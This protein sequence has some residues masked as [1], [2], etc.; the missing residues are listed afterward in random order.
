ML[1]GPDF[2]RS[3]GGKF[4]NMNQIPPPPPKK[5]RAAPQVEQLNPQN[6]R[7]VF[8]RLKFKFFVYVLAPS[9]GEVNSD[10]QRTEQAKANLDPRMGPRV[11]PRVRPREHP[12]QDPRGLISL[13]SGFS[14]T[15]TKAPAKRP[16]RASTEVSTKVSSQVVEVHLSC[17]HLF[18]SSAK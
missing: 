12:R 7:L 1:G 4:E 17:F 2:S 6:K 14:R 13:F 5:K 11:D 18:C 9:V 16:T 3:S 15:P 10:G 8:L